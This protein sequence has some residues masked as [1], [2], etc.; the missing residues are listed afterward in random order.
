MDEIRVFGRPG[1]AFGLYPEGDESLKRGILISEYELDFSLQDPN[2]HNFPEPY[3]TPTPAIA[4][5]FIPRELWLG[6]VS[7]PRF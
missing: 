3:I 1:G 7:G 5:L 4:T 6:Q 2:C